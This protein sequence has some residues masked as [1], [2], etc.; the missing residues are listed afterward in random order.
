MFPFPEATREN[1][2]IVRHV[3]LYVRVFEIT[4][5]YHTA[6]YTFEADSV[7]QNPPLPRRRSLAMLPFAEV[8]RED[9]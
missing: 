1:I 4:T 8:T 2:Q 7:A 6:F 3:S 5:F 9:I